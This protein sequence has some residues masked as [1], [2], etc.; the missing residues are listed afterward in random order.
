MST[1]RD[2]VLYE[3]FEGTA[4]ARPAHPA[5]ELGEAVLSYRELRE[6]SLALAARIVAEHGRAPDRVALVAAR[7]VAAY[8]AYLAIQR[9]G[10]CMVPLNPT[11]PAQ[12]NLD[13]AQR[14]AVEL[15]LVGSDAAELFLALPRRRRPTLLELDGDLPAGVPAEGEL[16]PVPRDVDREACL[17][18]T[19]GSTGQPKGVPIRHRNFS[20]YL[21]YNIAR[22]EVGPRSRLSQV[23][24]FT[25]DAHVFDLFVTWGGGGT[26]VVPSAA[27]LYAP[28]DFIVER[29]LTHWFSVP[30]VVRVAQQLSNLP[31]G[32]AVTVRHSI[33]GAEP[34]TVQDAELWREVAPNSKIHNVYGPTEVAITCADYQLPV[35][36]ARWPA[37][38]NGTVPIG[39]M[40]PFMDG[41][42]LD[43]DGL[44]AGDGELCVRGPQ[45]FDGYLD[46]QENL[47]RFVTW[48]DGEKA[49]VY[50]GT[51]P[52]TD[53]H[54]YRTGD[55][56]RRERDVL[57]HCGR[58]DHQVKVLGH[59][60]E[61][62]EVEAVIRRHPDVV[63]VAVVPVTVAGDTRLAAAYCGE[64]LEAA[65][66]EVWLRAQIP[67]PMVPV[68]VRR[69]DRMPLTDNGKIDRRL[70][71]EL[72]GESHD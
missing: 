67:L 20:P 32:R 45:R 65:A 42:V 58:L 18:F 6:K 23:F 9:L 33:F 27:E 39:A 5:L 12:R 44:P 59:R 66:F 54:W 71:A 2:R 60:I 25:F 72:L 56:V 11:H 35:D 55:R 3:W 43:E 38:S 17:L 29:S 10:A 68:R 49:A 37:P 28:V 34:V 48:E 57:V 16:P 4:L 69:L 70:L 64:E 47:D 26:L 14:A 40:H 31:L 15:A 13:I 21:A 1:V 62:G 22:Y 30:S 19:S 46:P 36:R 8:V 63:E 24:G 51:E 7:T 50:R 53:R 52:L 61:P 41:V